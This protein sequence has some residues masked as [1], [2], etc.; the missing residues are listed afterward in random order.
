MCAQLQGWSQRINLS[1]GPPRIQRDYGR[2]QVVRCIAASWKKWRDSGAHPEI[3][4]SIFEN[5]KL[6]PTLVVRTAPVIYSIRALFEIFYSNFTKEMTL[7]YCIH[8][9][10]LLDRP[11]DRKFSVSLHVYAENPHSI[12]S[13]KA[14]SFGKRHRNVHVKVTLLKRALSQSDGPNHALKSSDPGVSRSLMRA[15]C[16]LLMFLDRF[17]TY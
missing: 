9:R 14:V 7:Q 5:L 1:R 17:L 15:N 8:N 16:Q 10:Y 3:V 11:P 13:K 6:S 2:S 12:A 4:R